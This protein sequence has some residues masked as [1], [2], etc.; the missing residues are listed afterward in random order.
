LSINI[1]NLFDVRPQN[2]ING[3][4]IRGSRL[5]ET[6][7]ELALPDGLDPLADALERAD[8]LK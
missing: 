8:V 2:D 6:A 1:S 7:R 3:E 5:D 4:S